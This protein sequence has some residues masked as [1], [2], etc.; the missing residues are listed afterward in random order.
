VLVQI[1]DATGAVI[2]HWRDRNRVVPHT[3][4]TA[5]AEVCVIR[6]ACRDLGVVHM[7][8]I[9]ADAA[10]IPQPGQTSH[11]VL[12]ASTEPCP[13][14]YG[15]IAWARIPRLVFAASRSDA[16]RVGFADAALHAD[17]ARPYRDRAIVTVHRCVPDNALTAFDL[18]TQAADKTPY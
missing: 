8:R 15:A 10:R 5:H 14:C 12:Y 13:M 9:P 18:W 17:V 11:A 1:D 2:R 3:D 4:P 16:A 7:D 6:Q